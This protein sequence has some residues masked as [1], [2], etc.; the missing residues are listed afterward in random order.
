VPGREPFVSPAD[1]TWLI[2]CQMLSGLFAR[3]SYVPTY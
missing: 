2:L 1:C 3:R